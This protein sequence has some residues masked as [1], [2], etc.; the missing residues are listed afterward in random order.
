MDIVFSKFLM[1]PGEEL[2][3]KGQNHHVIFVLRMLI[4]LLLSSS[5]SLAVIEVIKTYLANLDSILLP[6]TSRWWSQAGHQAKIVP[7]PQKILTFILCRN[8]RMRGAL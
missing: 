4:R 7:M 1:S 2:H 6:S 8:C 3:Y 5:R